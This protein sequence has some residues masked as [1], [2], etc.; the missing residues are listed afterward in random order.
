MTDAKPF[1]VAT[2]N[3]VTRAL[4]RKRQCRR[5]LVADEVGLGK[6]IVA[7]EVIGQMMDSLKRPLR[8]I[9]VC[10]NL[11]IRGQ[12][13]DSLLKVL[14]ENERPS[15]FCHVDRL[16]LITDVDQ[17]THARLHLYSLTP[18]TNSRLKRRRTP[19]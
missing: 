10:S 16:S 8:V 11:A 2:V 12:N 7:R 13:Q 4:R 5:F 1:Q 9:Y 17:P 6:T 15:A 3:A 19:F 18:D 14:P